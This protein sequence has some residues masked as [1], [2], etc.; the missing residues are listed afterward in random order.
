MNTVTLNYDILAV[1]MDGTLLDPQGQLSP[2]NADALRRAR[3]AGLEIV[4]CTGRSLAEAGPI[5][6]QIALTSKIG[7]GEETKNGEVKRG[8][9]GTRYGGDEGDGEG[10]GGT[11]IFVGGAVT[12][13]LH[14]RQTRSRRKMAPEIVFPLARLLNEMTGH[15]VLLLKDR[16]VV[17]VDYR[18]VGSGEIDLASQWW[19]SHMPVAFD[20]CDQP[21]DDP[22]PDETVRISIVTNAGKMRLLS[23]AVR[24]QFADGIF[25]HDFPVTTADGNGR[26]LADLAIHLMEIFRKDTNKWTA[27]K[28]HADSRGV[29]V[30]RV[31]AIGDEVNDLLMI[32]NAGLGIAMGNAVEEV[33]RVAL[34]HTTSNRESGVA[35]AVDQILSGNW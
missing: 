21:E 8:G 7:G 9:K 31:A 17:G 30:N 12:V 14:T 19:F 23:K 1:D 4:L 10:G 13:D 33:K 27:L 18:L 32:K 11:G 16:S 35:A 34:K 28:E 25:T 3:N 22:H 15:R 2:E 26:H 24:A 5:I 29:A 6:E 20:T